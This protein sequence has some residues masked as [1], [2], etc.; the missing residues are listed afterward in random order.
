MQRE[1][2][3]T[4]EKRRLMPPQRVYRLCVENMTE[5]SSPFGIAAQCENE[6]DR[7]AFGRR[8]RE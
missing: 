3:L 6:L 8:S 5:D 2:A 4:L 7:H 1:P